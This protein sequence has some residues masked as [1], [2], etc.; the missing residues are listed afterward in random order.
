[1]KKLMIAGALALLCINLNA[2]DWS[3]KVY[4]VGKIYPGFY[5]TAAGDTVNGYFY[6]GNQ[7]QNQKECRF[8][9][10]EMD[11]RP[12]QVFKPEALKSWKVADKLY[13]S[14]N[15]S[16][17]LLEK[18]LRFNLVTNDGPICEYIFYNEDG[19]E[20]K[21]VYVKAHDEANSKP[22]ELQYFGMGFAKRMAEY[23][24]DYPELAKKI[25]DKEKGYGM[26]KILEIIQEYNTWYLNNKK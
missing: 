20:P 5:V 23:V 21:T 19:S 6:H 14:I 16:G 8:Y 13:R 25:T 11:P 9:K 3:G 4:K 1:M 18:P 22:R 15:Y 26:L 10:N 2:Q 12:A 24:A 7:T 17:G